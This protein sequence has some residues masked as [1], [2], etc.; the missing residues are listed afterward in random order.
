M[1]LPNSEQYLEDLKAAQDLLNR[2]LSAVQRSFSNKGFSEVAAK[3]FNLTNVKKDLNENVSL[4]VPLGTPVDISTGE[5]SVPV[6]SNIPMQPEYGA[7]GV[8][9]INPVDPSQVIVGNPST[10]VATDRA[11][12]DKSQSRWITR[13]IF[14]FR[15]ED[16]GYD[17]CVYEIPVQYLMEG[18]VGDEGRHSNTLNNYPY[19]EEI[20]MISK[21]TEKNFIHFINVQYE[22]GHCGH[23]NGR[24]YNFMCVFDRTKYGVINSKGDAYEK[25]TSLYVN[26][27][28]DSL[29]FYKDGY[30]Y[31]PTP[32]RSYGDDLLD[33]LWDCRV[34][35]REDPPLRNLNIQYTLENYPVELGSIALDEVSMID[36]INGRIVLYKENNIDSIVSD[37]RVSFDKYSS[38]P[39]SLTIN[40]KILINNSKIKCYP[41]YD[42]EYVLL[43]DGESEWINTNLPNKIIQVSD[44]VLLGISYLD[45]ADK[46]TRK[47]S[48]SYALFKLNLSTY[49][50]ILATENPKNYPCNNTILDIEGSE[51]LEIIEGETVKNHLDDTTVIIYV[52]TVSAKYKVTMTIL[53]DQVSEIHTEKMSDLSK[54]GI[55]TIERISSSQVLLIN[56]DNGTVFLDTLSD[57][58]YVENPFNLENRITTHY[59]GRYHLV[60]F[61][62][63]RVLAHCDYTTSQKFPTLPT[64]GTSD[65]DI[66]NVVSRNDIKLHSQIFNIV[67]NIN[68]NKKISILREKYMLSGEFLVNPR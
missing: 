8:K 55:A 1:I 43:Q 28:E 47:Q 58:Q 46:I 22:D 68:G 60:G 38:I 33:T 19:P 52:Y 45:I 6:Y 18:I 10:T 34:I 61:E 21:D 44:T 5:S 29:A 67:E 17:R 39:L 31:L 25:Y 40:H 49:S 42:T 65:D 50:P 26:V 14:R 48:V 37:S 16:Y 3:G 56:I 35:W 24:D 11:D 30:L 9:Y 64:D 32:D 27:I 36:S 53:G 54:I 12:G 62:N 41:N 20:I 15:K 51:I 23:F 13:C 59:L 57:T 66:A 2:N 63:K 7:K 4:I